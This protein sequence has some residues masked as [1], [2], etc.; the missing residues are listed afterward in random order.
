MKV[1]NTFRAIPGIK[2]FLENIRAAKTKPFLIHCFGRI[3]SRRFNTTPSLPGIEVSQ[4]FADK[5]HQRYMAL[6]DPAGSGGWD[7]ERQIDQSSK[8]FFSLAEETDHHGTLF[9]GFD[10]SLYH[11]FRFT[12]GAETYDHIAARSKR[13]DLP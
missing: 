2:I 8:W 12:T 11:V 6:L 10:H 13:I 5:M 4:T 9:P 7:L 1:I 3:D